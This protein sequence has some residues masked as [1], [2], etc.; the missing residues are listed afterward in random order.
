MKNF[1]IFTGVGDYE[2][3]YQSWALNKSNIFDRAIFYYGNNEERYKQILS[4][5]TEYCYKKP[6]MIW[7]NFVFNYQEFNNYDYVLVVDS[8]LHLNPNDLEATFQLAK[9]NNWSAC[10]WSRD[11]KSY[12]WFVPLYVQDK[13]KKYKQTNFIEMLFLMLRKDVCN[14]LVSEYKRLQLEYST[15]IDL[16]LSNVAL[17]KNYLPFYI[18]D[19]YKFYNPWPHDKKNGREVDVI[20]GI[21]GPRRIHILITHFN[22]NKLKYKITHPIHFECDN[23]KFK[24]QDRKT[25]IWHL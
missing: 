6:G 4:H 10:Q 14:D 5:N 7:S 20:T 16:L 21:D 19:E 11:E 24:Y 12:G 22:A 1:L 15:G 8:D 25:H 9:E 23:K 17:E 13:S 3:Q 18:V 2:N